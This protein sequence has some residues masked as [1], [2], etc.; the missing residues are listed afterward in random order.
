M[1]IAGDRSAGRYSHQQEIIL[2]ATN[3]VRTM[4]NVTRLTAAIALAIAA[5]APA[6][7]QDSMKHVRDT[8][9]VSQATDGTRAQAY[10]PLAGNPNNDTP[11]TI[12]GW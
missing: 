4:K 1:W 2:V 5:S 9:S 3:G 6:F 7:A 12:L 11:D 10:V 8:Q